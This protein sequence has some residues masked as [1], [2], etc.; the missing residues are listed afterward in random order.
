M[1]HPSLAVPERKWKRPCR[2]K[3]GDSLSKQRL[4][5]MDFERGQLRSLHL[6]SN[7][8]G[9]AI[10][11]M[12]LTLFAGA[13]GLCIGTTSLSL[14]IGCSIVA[15]VMTSLLFVVGHDACHQSLMSRRWLNRLVGTIAFLP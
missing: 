13:I 9:A 14:K 5:A 1:V 10:F 3:T 12:D 15:G 11:L 4:A 6:R 8:K 2:S 7:L